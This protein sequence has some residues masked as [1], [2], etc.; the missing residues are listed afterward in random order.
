ME[1][2]GYELLPATLSNAYGSF[3]HPAKLH[4]HLLLPVG[5]LATSFRSLGGV[6]DCFHLVSHSS[7]IS[8]PTDRK[9]TCQARSS[10]SLSEAY[11]ILKKVFGFSF[12]YR[13]TA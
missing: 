13:F 11:L 10:P 3:S 12:T 7:W 2:A 6:I 4:W 9:M 8:M 1:I 5:W